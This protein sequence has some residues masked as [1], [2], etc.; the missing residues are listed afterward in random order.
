MLNKYHAILRKN[1]FTCLFIGTPNKF[2]IQLTFT[3]VCMKEKTTVF[4]V[5][6]IAL[7]FVNTNGRPSEIFLPQSHWLCYLSKSALVTKKFDE[8]RKV[9]SIWD[10]IYVIFL[11]LEY[12]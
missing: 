11:W 9:I 10:I 5:N 1:V 2:P 6:I 7:I 4:F 8:L 12:F 3:L